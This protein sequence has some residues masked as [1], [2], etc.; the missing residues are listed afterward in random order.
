[1][2]FRDVELKHKFV[3]DG[4]TY[5]KVIPEHVNCCQLKLNAKEIN[6]QKGVVIKDNVAVEPYVEDTTTTNSENPAEG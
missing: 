3:L 6:T 5:I 1:M 4:L 2:K